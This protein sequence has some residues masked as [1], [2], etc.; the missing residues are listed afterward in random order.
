MFREIHIALD[1]MI[2]TS[3]VGEGIRTMWF[4]KH[5]YSL[6]IVSFSSHQFGVCYVRFIHFTN[7]VVSIDSSQL[8]ASLF[9]LM[10]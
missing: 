8:T 2:H 3:S 4:L 7:A 9:I 1:N 5:L 10:E 6:I